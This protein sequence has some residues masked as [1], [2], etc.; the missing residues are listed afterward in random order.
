MTPWAADLVKQRRAD[1]SKDNPE[2]NSIY[3]FDPNGLRVELTTWA[4]DEEYLQHEATVARSR[5][6]AWTR[7]KRE[8]RLAPGA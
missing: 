4:V 5:L 7:R 1:N 3:F 8:G 6:D 2:A